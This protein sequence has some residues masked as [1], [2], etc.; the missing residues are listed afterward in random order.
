MYGKLILSISMAAAA[1]WAQGQPQAQVSRMRGEKPTQLPPALVG[2]GIQQKLNAPVPLDAVFSDEAGRSVALG[3]FFGEK[4]VLLA[5]VYYQCPMLC[6]Q[7]L[8]GVEISLKAVKLDPGRDFEVVVVSFDPADTPE[9]AAAKKTNYL[10]RYGRPNTANGW[11]FLTGT[12]PNIKALTDAVGFYYRW[13]PVNK[14]FAHA[15]GI[16]VATPQG[17]LSHYFYGVE[18]SPRD[19]RLALVES[20]QEKIGSPV[21]AIL[22]YCYHYDPAAG[23]YG[24][25]AMHIV[26][27][28]GGTFVLIGSVFL[29]IM[30]RRDWRADRQAL[31]RV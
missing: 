7:I 22:L 8:N 26:R 23:K 16:F 6:T 17:R 5:L 13:D 4:P 31:R 28:G 20:S 25:V 19:I 11:H 9:L 14:Q 27:L 29:F 21:D 15:S 12:P 1:L 30:W 18:Y 24:A 10:R 2:V 3:S